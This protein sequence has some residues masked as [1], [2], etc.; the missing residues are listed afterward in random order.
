MSKE[1]IWGANVDNERTAFRV[2]VEDGMCLTYENDELTNRLSYTVPE[3]PEQ[4]WIDEVLEVWGKRCRFQLD[5][6]VPYLQMDGKWTASDTTMDAR[7]KQ[8]AKNQKISGIVQA[9]I[10]LALC[11]V[12][13]II[14]LVNDGDMGNW[15]FSAIIGSIMIVT[16]IMQY[17]NVKAEFG[18]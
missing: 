8:I 17:R 12:C 18:V 7:M 2:V 3:D 11:L 9:V 6:G 4:M 14:Y 1:F 13:G 5:K 15:W 16:G 10:G